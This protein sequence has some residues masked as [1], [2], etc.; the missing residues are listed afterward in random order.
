MHREIQMEEFIHDTFPHTE[1]QGLTQTN[2]R[3]PNWKQQNYTNISYVTPL[4]ESSASIFLYL[5]KHLTEDYKDFLSLN[6]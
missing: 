3:Y 5:Q 6:E 2:K 4:Y 1:K